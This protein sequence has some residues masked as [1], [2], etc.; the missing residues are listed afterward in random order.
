MRSGFGLFTSMT[1][2]VLTAACGFAGDGVPTSG[3]AFASC[4][5]PGPGPHTVG[6]MRSI[7]IAMPDGTPI[8]LD[9]VLPEGGGQSEGARFPAVLTMTRYWRSVEGAPPNQVQE[10]WVSHGYAVVWGDVRGTGA[11]SGVWPHH[12]SR[13]ETRDFGDVIDWIVEQPWSDGKVAGWGS[14]Y[15]ANTVDWMVER[16]RPSLRAAMSRFPDYDPYVNLYFPGGIQNAYMGRNWG[17]R[18]KEMDLNVKRGNPP[19]GI[20]PVDDDLTGSLLEDVVAARRDVPSVWEGLQQV[21]FKDDKPPSWSG[22]SM[23]DWGIHA[24]SEAV[25][26]SGTP[27]ISW[28]G[29]LDA[30]TAEGVLRRFMTVSNPQRVMVGP[31]SH[32]GGHHVS[33]FLAD[34]APTD[35]PQLTQY[36]EDLCFL[37]QRVKERDVGMGERLLVYYTMGEERWKTTT[38]WPLPGTV[39]QD[40]YLGPDNSFSAT[41]A[42][43]G[44]DAAD[45]YEVNFDHTTGTQ[46]RWATN[47]GAGD[48]FYTDRVQQD[49]LLLVYESEPLEDDLEVTGY[50]VAD[51]YVSSTHDDGAFFVYLEDVGPD[52]RVRYITEGQLRALHRKVSDEAPPYVIHGPY[53]SFLRKDGMP[54]VPGEV[55]RLAFELMPTSVVFQAGHRIRIAIAGADKD[56]FRRI[57]EEG[58]ATIR[59]HRSTNYPS[60]IILPVIPRD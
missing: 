26:Q 37:E 34:D 35:P 15:T 56:T 3:Y 5:E 29:W 32:G 21:T 51:L 10:F 31:W 7:H 53:H 60:R 6:P 42:D 20:K 12:R 4:I 2:A 30:G 48:V 23:D 41:P 50:P 40:W 36:S 1:A 27:I 16:A 39:Q 33:P 14:S 44:E 24:W 38:E 57:P 58:S 8:A 55:A 9:I 45:A 13:A 47:N 52:G 17:L 59:V 54:L 18:V 43:G 22:W 49:A 19:V 28:A 11:S 46:N 25:Q